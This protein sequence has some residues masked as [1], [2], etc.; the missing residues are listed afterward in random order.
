[1]LRSDRPRAAARPS[2]KQRMT[3]DRR[4]SVARVMISCMAIVGEA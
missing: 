1:M 2:M 4:F 3:G